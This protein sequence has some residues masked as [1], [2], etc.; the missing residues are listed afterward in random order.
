LLFEVL[1]PVRVTCGAEA[2]LVAGARQRNLIGALLA[3]ANQLVPVDRLAGFV[4]DGTP[5]AQAVPALRTHIARLRRTLGP[6]VSSRIMTRDGSY[7]ATAGPGELDLLAFE[8]LHRDAA[9]AVRAADWAKTSDLASAALALWHGTAFEDVPSQALRDMWLP[10]LDQQRFQVT[11]WHAEAGLHLGR[12][13]QLL[14][15][16]RRLTTAYPL[17]ERF[18]AQLIQA[19]DRC[20]R[21]ADALAAFQDARRALVGELGIEPGAELR[22]LHE[23]ILSGANDLAKERPAVRLPP[24]ALHA[25]VPCQLPA[26]AGHFTGRHCEMDLITGPHRPGP[27]ARSLDAAVAVSAISGMPGVGKTALAV[28][29]AHRL[30]GQFPDGQLFIDLHGYTPGRLPREPGEALAILQRSLGVPPAQIPELPEESAALYRQHLAGTRT[31]VVLDNARSEAQVRPLLPGT[32]GCLVLVTSRRRLKGLYHAQA[33]ALDV[34]PEADACALL[35]A[36]L[37]PAHGSLPGPEL[38]EIAGLCGRLPLALHMAGALLRHRSGWTL[39]HLARLL[40]DENRRMAAFSDGDHD[41][42]AVIDLSYAALNGQEQSLFRRLALVPGPEFDVFAAAALLECDPADAARH[43]ESL[44]DHNLLTDRGPGRYRLHDLIRAR[45][46]ALSGP[47]PQ[48]ARADF[49]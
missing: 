37:A 8:A 26:V 32:P 43:L 15:H 36:A 25:T 23:Q 31:L 48:R 1:G 5:P 9:T 27:Q 10:H 35:A 40:R 19:L 20:G 45:A 28:Q 12:H 39:E 11:E 7:L 16:L 29:A 34:L 49:Q 2:R 3:H 18:H 38:T 47:R 42:N 13:E 33:V 44:V 46:R 30:A 24:R 41:L 17:H 22:R 14:P 21:Q 6:A 4:W